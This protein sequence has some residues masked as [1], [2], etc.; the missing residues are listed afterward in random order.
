MDSLYLYDPSIGAAGAFIA[1]FGI[2]TIAQCY[3]MYRYRSIYYIPMLVGSLFEVVGMI[4]RIVSTKN[5]TVIAPFAVQ[6]LFVLLAPLLFAAS[7]YMTL[8]QLLKFLNSPEVSLIP[9]KV[10]TKLFVTGDIVSFLL[11][12]A[13]G[14]MQAVEG[15]E[16]TRKVGRVIIIIGLV[17]QLVF[18]CTFIF[19]T[20]I[21]EIRLYKRNTPRNPG[22]VQWQYIIWELYWCSAFILIRSI[23]R[24]VE[25]AQ[26]WT[27]E[28][29]SKEYYFYV[30]DILMM[31]LLMVL[32]SVIHPGMVI[33]PKAADA[34]DVEL[35]ESRKS[36]TERSH[37]A[38][39]REELF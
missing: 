29:Q 38:H 35:L 28:L 9:S 17:V 5:P 37:S 2:T 15:D 16:N 36:S 6:L 13:G 20:F 8:S 27:G 30:L 7:M 25:F 1:L 21:S 11:Q 24:V 10:S 14:G 18:F 12:A 31:F 4:V 3:W 19:V 39:P 34:L 33:K 23:F 26:G 22:K 32:V